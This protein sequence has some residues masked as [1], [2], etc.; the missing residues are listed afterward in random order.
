MPSI[1]YPYLVIGC[2][3]FRIFN[4]ITVGPQTAKIQILVWFH[5]DTIIILVPKGAS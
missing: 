1:Y 5:N 2:L 4:Y 3:F